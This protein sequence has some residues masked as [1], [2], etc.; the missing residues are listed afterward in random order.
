VSDN[1]PPLNNPP[2]RDI[3]NKDIHKDISIGCGGS[4]ADEVIR[5]LIKTL[6][7]HEGATD[8]R[9]SEVYAS[10]ENGTIQKL[11]IPIPWYSPEIGGFLLREVVLIH[12][13]KLDPE[14]KDR[15]RKEAMKVRYPDSRRLHESS[16]TFIFC[17]RKGETR[18][19]KGLMP[20]F[21]ILKGPKAGYAFY[22]L[23][24]NSL[25]RFV[26]GIEEGLPRIFRSTEKVIKMDRALVSRLRELQK[27]ELVKLNLVGRTTRQNIKNL[28][29]D[30]VV[31]Q[32]AKPDN[33][34]YPLPTTSVNWGVTDG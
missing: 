9:P 15:L 13:E 10:N 23:L 16:S 24:A 6:K 32:L 29:T 1:S 5:A 21:T 28:M 26:D 3:Y 8:Y 11:F 27:E 7:E 22:K 2:H 14:T 25:E 19:T 34:T 12:T 4:Y 31:R 18:S 30:E 20:C 17:T 33:I